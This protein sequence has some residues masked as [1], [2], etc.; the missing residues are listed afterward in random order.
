MLRQLVIVVGVSAWVAAC[1]SSS[2]ATPP[3]D[4][5]GDADGGTDE[6]DAAALPNPMPGCPLDPGPTAIDFDPQSATDPLG[7][8]DKLTIAQA[9]AGYPDS[10][11]VLTALIT[12]EKGAI[13]C[14][15]DEAAAPIS[16]ANF[17]ALARGTRPYKTST[18]WKVG[19][20]YD[21]LIFHR[22]IPN[23]VIQGGDPRGTGTGGPGYSLP[24]E[25]HVDEPAG[26]LA[27]AASDVPSGSQFYIVVGQ[28]PQANYNVFGKC[29]TETAITIASEKR[30]SADK[31]VTDVHM[32]RIDIAR[33]PK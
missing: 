8:A 13:R 4:V 24:E 25:N 9:L 18:R 26:T 27:M 20:F 15:L 2:P 3:L 12:T 11:G 14:E 1:S 30:D 33:C 10:S 28:G 19:R 7:G 23:F 16:V 32:Q 5:S 17:V 22:V 6:V 21:G 31:P 29:E